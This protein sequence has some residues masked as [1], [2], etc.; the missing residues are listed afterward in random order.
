MFLTN[1][2]KKPLSITKLRIHVPYEIALSFTGLQIDESSLTIDQFI[3]YSRT[4]SLRA[5]TKPHIRERPRKPQMS[6][7]ASYTLSFAS[8]PNRQ[9][10]QCPRNEPSN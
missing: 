10:T 4:T 8:E 6:K 3:T 5:Y 2:K 1:L 9:T 7:A